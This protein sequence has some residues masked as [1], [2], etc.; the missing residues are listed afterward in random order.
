MRSASAEA[1][2]DTVKTVE[3]TRGSRQ[4]VKLCEYN[5]RAAH[6]FANAFFSVSLYIVR[7]RINLSLIQNIFKKN[8]CFLRYTLTSPYGDFMYI[9]LQF[10]FSVKNKKCL[11]SVKEKLGSP[12]K[13][14]EIST[15]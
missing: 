5:T 13:F 11:I 2:H 3:G 15:F 10:I 4:L 1:D 8:T 14:N 9:V 12:G 6:I 7:F